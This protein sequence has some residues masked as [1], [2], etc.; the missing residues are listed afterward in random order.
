MLDS[1][2]VI[3][4]SKQTDGENNIVFT[5][6]VAEDTLPTTEPTTAR[7]VQ[8]QQATEKGVAVLPYGGV[9]FGRNVVQ[10]DASYNPIV[11][12][13]KGET[14]TTGEAGINGS[15][16]VGATFILTRVVSSGGGVIKQYV[17]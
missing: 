8:T 15:T 3:V 1:I 13:I 4:E 7:F 14:Y 16:E 5:L 2:H 17:H 6:R 11:A 9:I 10:V 12:T